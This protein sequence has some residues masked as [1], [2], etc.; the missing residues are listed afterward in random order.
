MPA[1]GTGGTEE[2]LNRL[3]KLSLNPVDGT[4][5]L[6]DLVAAFGRYLAL[7]QDAAHALVF[8]VLHA[9]CLPIATS[10]PRLATT[11]PQKRCGKTTL[12]SVLSKPVPRPLAAANITPAAIYRATEACTPRLL[13][14]EADTFLRDN[15]ELRGVLNSGQALDDLPT[16][17]LDRSTCDCVARE[18]RHLRREVG[19]PRHDAK[20]V[21][22]RRR[23]LEDLKVNLLERITLLTEALLAEDF[24]SLPTGT[25]F[26]HV[27]EI[28][29]PQLVM[30][31]AGKF[32]IGS[33]E[34][35]AERLEDEGPQHE[36]TIAEAFA[37]GRYAVTFNEY[38]HFCDATDCQK[39]SDQRWG[40]ERRPVTN[41]SYYDASA[42]CNWLSDATGARLQLPTEAMWKYACRIGT[43]TCFS[44][45]TNITTNQVNYNGNHP[46]AEGPRA[47]SE[48]RRY[49]SVRCLRIVGD[50]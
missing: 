42:Y 49:P 2:S 18:L 26:R 27:P 48:A 44:F 19:K 46:Y 16:S 39:P 6:N 35:E 7:T 38:D 12:V 21:D 23:R 13:L 29:C 9:F 4:D 36:V 3:A 28:C 24:P 31:P 32:L 14:D 47:S 11:S 8:R 22:E 17:G 20:I 10:N 40:R 33:P 5:L 37:L 41:V 30:I 34:E 1:S 15:H 50:V 43:T 45:G 25:V